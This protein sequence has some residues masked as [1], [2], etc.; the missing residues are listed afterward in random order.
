[1]N[2]IGANTNRI[3]ANMNRIEA[4][5][6]RT[7]LVQKCMRLHVSVHSV[8]RHRMFCANYIHQHLARLCP[9]KAMST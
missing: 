3:G 5:M 9:S 2:R 7:V 6:N 4:N 8:S 1:M